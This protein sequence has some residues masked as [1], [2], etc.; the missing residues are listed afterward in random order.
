MVG[1]NVAGWVSDGW[2]DRGDLE[3]ILISWYS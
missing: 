1:L 2:D 3:V